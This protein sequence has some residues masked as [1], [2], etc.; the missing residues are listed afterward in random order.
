MSENQPVFSDPAALIA[1][2]DALMAE[3]DANASRSGC[4]SS[5]TPSPSSGTQPPSRRSGSPSASRNTRW[6]PGQSG[7]PQGRPR[8]PS[9]G[10]ATPAVQR[11]L[12][13]R[14][15]V[16][17][18]GQ[19]R[20]LGLTEAL[21]RAM[22]G[23]ALAGDVA[24]ARELLLALADTE[25]ARAARSQ[26]RAERRKAAAAEAERARREAAQAAERAR[27]LEADRERRRRWKARQA[28]E[29]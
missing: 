26:A 15:E 24:A 14:V 19:P 28:G 5:E 22:A 3:S 25:R 16:E 13:L 23:R 17:V 27:R 20:R 9:E 29:D 8:R 2:V 7:N 18:D 4:A 21:V 1:A 12:S 6:K 11:A 10:L